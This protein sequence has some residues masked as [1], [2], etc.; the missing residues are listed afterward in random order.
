[1]VE[2]DPANSTPQTIPPQMQAIMKKSLKSNRWKKI[3]LGA[4]E[5]YTHENM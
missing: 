4:A 1:M 5:A 2:S 3:D